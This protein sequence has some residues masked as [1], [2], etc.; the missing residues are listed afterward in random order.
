MYC[1]SNLCVWSELCGEA[2]AKMII[3]GMLLFKLLKTATELSSDYKKHIHRLGLQEAE[4]FING[5]LVKKADIMGV[6]ETGKRLAQQNFGGERS[7]PRE[8]A[9]GKTGTLPDLGEKQET[10]DYH[11]NLKMPAQLS[12]DIVKFQRLKY[13]MVF[14]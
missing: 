7:K 14:Q 8:I 3:F 1:S 10:H 12:R 2:S 4:K 13:M 11:P 5:V 9:F 6:K